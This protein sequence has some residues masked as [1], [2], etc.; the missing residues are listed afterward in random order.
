MR[1][2]LTTPRL[3]LEPLTLEHTELLVELDADP[4]VLRHIFGRAL[5]RSEVV[6]RW[7]PHRTRPE[8]DERGLGYW[9]GFAGDTFL[10]WWCLS[11]DPDPAAAELGYRLR[12]TTWGQGYATEGGL[13]LLAHGFDTVG[14]DLV[15]AETM[16]VNTG[17][18]AVMARCGLRH[19]STEV[20]AWA[21]PLPGA[22]LGEVRYE[23]TREEW[24]ARSPEADPLRRGGG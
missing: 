15:W 9:V 6:E 24:A 12:R 21:D 17:S 16:A 3:R 23:I 14:L 22:E 2:R 10:G 20:R 8:A 4:E 7:M 19:V 18:R 11:L 5:S 1:P 13:A